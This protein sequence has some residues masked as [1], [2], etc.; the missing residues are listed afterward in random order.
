MEVKISV[1]MG[2]YQPVSRQVLFQ[3]VLSIGL[4]DLS[5]MGAD[6]GR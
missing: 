4:P 2:V 3:A 1:I 5:G 6:H